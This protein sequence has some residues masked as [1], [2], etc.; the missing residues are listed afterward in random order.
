MQHCNLGTMVEWFIKEDNDVGLYF[1]PNN[2]TFQHVFWA[3]KLG[4]EGF[5]DCKPLISIVAHTYMVIF[6][7]PYWPRLPKM[8][9]RKSF[10]LDF[11][12][13]EKECIRTWSWFLASIR[14]H[15]MQMMGLRI[16][17]DRHADILTTMLEP[18]W[19]SPHAHH[20]FCLRHLL[21]NYNH[22]NG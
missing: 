20:M 17:Y 19:Q 18:K 5:K 16:I 9:T 13:V 2:R 4:I 15:V 7:I 12:L 22:Q 8:L 10:P 21:S 3:F 14:K 11:A 6:V 1:R